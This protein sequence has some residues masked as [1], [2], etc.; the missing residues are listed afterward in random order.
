M[1]TTTDDALAPI[2][3][4]LSKPQKFIQQHYLANVRL[5]LGYVAVTIA[6][7]LFYADWK[8][9][10]D[11]TKVYTAPACVAYFILNSALTYWLWF[12]ESGKVFV[13]V[14][15]GGQKV[16]SIQ[17]LFWRRPCSHSL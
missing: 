17:R 1:K 6:G 5:A 10:W 13:G 15:E 7:V 2:F 9:G 11:A 8:L 4:S 16:C 12:V 14:R 3:S